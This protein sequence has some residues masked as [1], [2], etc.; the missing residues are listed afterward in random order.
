MTNSS[1]TNASEIQPR[2]FISSVEKGYEDMRNAAM[3]AIKRAGCVP[4]RAEDFPAA[5]I[6]PRSACLDGVASCDVIVFILGARYGVPTSVGISAVE[7]EYTEAKR[8]QKQILL[9]IEETRYEQPQERFIQSITAYVSGHWR[10]LFSSIEELESLIE[11]T[12]REMTPMGDTNSEGAARA[13]IN[14]AFATRPAK[15]DSIVWVQTVWTT[16]RDEEVIDSVRFTD[17]SFRDKVQVLGHSAEVRLLDYALG[18]QTLAEASRLHISQG[19]TG[20]WREGRSLVELDIYEN[21]T[22][23]IA[24]NVTG[25]NAKTRPNDDISELY[26]I[27]PDM[28]SQRLAL[29]FSFARGWWNFID[30]YSRHEPLLYNLVLH[31]VG[32]R[33]LEKPVAHQNSFSIPWFNPPSL[34]RFY[35]HPR[36][37]SRAELESPSPTIEHAM[38]IL[39]M[40]FQELERAR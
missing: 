7:E 8:L 5:K 6:A 19:D 16:L 23:S 24:L 1:N 10:R 35:E 22:L 39:K 32:T 15:N 37:I 33:R 31:D 17:S 9:F 13:R 4:I 26:Q 18:K 20:N 29:A 12:L 40:R 21:G 30:P 14:A 34:L 27:D 36:R 3:R 11:Q 2:V 25:V 38:T 28:V